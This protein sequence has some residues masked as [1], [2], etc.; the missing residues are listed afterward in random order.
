[1]FSIFVSNTS[2]QS[3]DTRKRNLSESNSSENATVAIMSNYRWKRS[4]QFNFVRL[5]LCW[6]FWMNCLAT[7]TNSLF[8]P[9]THKIIF[10]IWF[11]CGVDHGSWSASWCDFQTN[12]IRKR[13]KN[14]RRPVLA[15]WLG[16]KGQIDKTPGLKIE[17]L[18]KSNWI[19][20][21]EYISYLKKIILS[22]FRQWQFIFNIKITERWSE[23]CWPKL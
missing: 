8:V 22:N 17:N 19:V 1:M 21:Q 9:P 18:K 14:L 3:Q 10:L 6:L 12:I 2:L 16:A 4:L 13:I 20:V 23:E 15:S 5:P 7:N 11:F